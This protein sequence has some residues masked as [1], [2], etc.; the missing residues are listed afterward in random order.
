MEQ[1]THDGP[2]HETAVGRVLNVD[3]HLTSRARGGPRG[4]VR[5]SGYVR[6]GRI[7]GPVDVLHT[8]TGF[9]KRCIAL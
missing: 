8:H 4:W 2:G 7:W 1:T 6:K 3:V 5:V 9:A